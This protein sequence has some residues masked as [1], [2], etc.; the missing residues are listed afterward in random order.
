MSSY[1]DYIQLQHDFAQKCASNSYDLR[2][3]W[4]QMKDGYI[5][6]NMDIQRK[7]V[8]TSSQ[9]QQLYDTL[10]F[11]VR[12][13]EFHALIEND[14]KW[15]V[16][17]GRQRFTCLFNI[18][19]DKIPLLKSTASPLLQ[20]LFE[21]K[22]NQQQLS[23]LPNEVYFSE[24][25]PEIQ[26]MI[27]NTQITVAKYSNLTR[28]EQ[29][30]LFRKINN[31]T[32]LSCLAKGLASY[33]YMRTDY[34]ELILKMAQF[35][36]PVFLKKNQEDIECALIRMLL[37]VSSDKNRDLQQQS[38]EKYYSEFENIHVLVK[39]REKVID[40]I[41]RIPA[42]ERIV[43]NQS[44]CTLFPFIIWGFYKHPELT[45]QQINNIFID[46]IENFG[47]GRGNDLGLSGVTKRKDIIEAYINKH[48]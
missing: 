33:Y 38:L 6:L 7:Y 48:K 27:F 42:I 29:I 15:Q 8:W 36:N 47:S 1:E 23:K 3:V 39:E 19:D 24:M 32:A 22:M 2:Y 17:D 26:G 21:Y 30:L 31:G 13:P 45:S 37:L 44:W 11:Q 40:T 16:C 4:Q 28:Q 5:N 25:P 46:L 18:L 12:I 43:K 14:L 20:F 41:N 35:Q 9:E 10:L 34:S